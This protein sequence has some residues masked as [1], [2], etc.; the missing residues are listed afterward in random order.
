METEHSVASTTPPSLKRQLEEVSATPAIL[1]QGVEQSDARSLKRSR[2]HSSPNNAGLST[3]G[4]AGL[5]VSPLAKSPRFTPRVSPAPLTGA[6]AMED[7]RREREEQQGVQARATSEN[8]G[9][10][11]ISSLIS[12]TAGEMSRP[13]D[14]PAAATTMSDGLSMAAKTISILDPMQI[15]ERAETS[16]ASV[17]SVASLN[18]TAP[19]A[20]AST[21]GLASPSNAPMQNDI[22]QRDNPASNY[23]EVHPSLGEKHPGRALTFPGNEIIRDENKSREQARGMSLPMPGMG[24]QQHER[25]PGAKSNKCPHCDAQFTR[26]HNLKSHLLTHSQEKPFHCDSCNMRFRRLHDLKRHTKLHTGERPHICPKC[27]RK[28][29]RGDALARHAKGQGGCAG[30]RASMGSFGDGDDYD[31]PHLGDD[32]GMDGVMFDGAA[33]HL[34]DG[35]LEDD[36]RRYSLPT[37][38]ATHVDQHGQQVNYPAQPRPSSTYPPS[39]PRASQPPPTYQQN[40][41]MRQGMNA[42]PQANMQGVTARQSMPPAAAPLNNP[43]FSPMQI[44]ESPKA[45]SPGMTGHPQ[46]HNEP[47]TLGRQRSPSLATALQQQSF[48]RRQSERVSSPQNMSVPSPLGPKLPSLSGLAPPES[49]YTLPSQ[50]GNQQASTNGVQQGQQEQQTQQSSMSFQP[51]MSQPPQHQHNGSGDSNNSAN[52]FASEK[53]VFTYITEQEHQWSERLATVE[54]QWSE[55]L[56]NVEREKEEK[57]RKLTEKAAA[58]ESVLKQQQLQIQQL[59]QH[60][61]QLQQSQQQGR[62]MQPFN[63]HMQQQQQQQ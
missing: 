55:R 35:S 51:Q 2:L 41:D 20:T 12:G 17:T 50:A 8:P 30:R 32:S 10:R 39:G 52:L 5:T 27:D 14:A 49:R 1:M 31:D 18:S 44:T 48:M 24:Q 59:Q 9:F 62:P 19:T 29:A 63:G 21:A 22:Q 3:I 16:P 11:A 6:A 23:P 33:E 15:E 34:G 60:T 36:D 45:L 28:F 37:I 58:M 53:N 46:P 57:I 7:Q 47:S 13:Q 56:E 61:Q 42:A 40:P 43:A 4:D 25:S 38:K 54:R 26:Q